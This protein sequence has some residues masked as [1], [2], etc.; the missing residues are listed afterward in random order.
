LLE[1]AV[2]WSDTTAPILNN[3]EGAALLYEALVKAYLKIGDEDSSSAAVIPFLEWSRAIHLP[4]GV[5]TGTA[6]DDLAGKEVDCLLRGAEYLVSTGYRDEA[7]AVLAEAR[8][9]A[10]LIFNATA[11]VTKYIYPKPVANPIRNHLIGGYA[12]ARAHTQAL[13]L[14]TTLPFS[15]NRNDAIHY[16]ANAYADRN[17][18]PGF[19]L[20]SIDTDGDGKPDFFNPLA[21][22]ED[23]AASGLVLDDDTDGDGIPDAS[24]ARPL[25]PD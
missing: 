25:Y 23:I 19:W 14:A 2:T 1:L 9:T 10:D 6:H 20:A 15:A 24:D 12:D 21:S 11:R 13:A 17:D 3:A 4:G 7:L 8:A 5:Y 22:T 16:L 18:F